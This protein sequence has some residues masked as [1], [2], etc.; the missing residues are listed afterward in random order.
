[1][2][3]I[4]R[5]D[6]HWAEG[7]LA[8]RI[9]IFPI[10]FVHCNQAAK[11]I[12]NSRTL[13]AVAAA[14]SSVT[15]EE[16]QSPSA[17]SPIATVGILI[18]TASVC[19][20]TSPSVLS[21]PASLA[22]VSSAVVASTSNKRYS[23]Q[24][25]S[26]TQTVSSQHRRSMEVPNYIGLGMMTSLSP[27]STADQTVTSPGTLAGVENVVSAQ[28]QSGPSQSSPRCKSSLPAM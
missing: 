10:S 1:M 22:A 21:Y 13:G 28:T 27:T 18:T 14:Q 15:S 20:V 7:R 23:L 19:A 9:G 3:V 16:V 6:E 8:D 25:T 4:R 11:R 24:V 17:T 12:L 5:V 2:V 26:P